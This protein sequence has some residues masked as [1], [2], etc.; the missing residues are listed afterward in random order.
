MQLYAIICNRI[1]LCENVDIRFEANSYYIYARVQ[2]RSCVFRNMMKNF[3]FQMANAKY[4]KKKNFM[5]NWKLQIGNLWKFL[6]MV[7]LFFFFT[8]YALPFIL[9]RAE[10][11]A[12]VNQT[13]NFQGKIINKTGGTNISDGTY[14]FTFKIYDASSGGNQLWSET[15]SSVSVT[16][17][18]FQVALGSTTPLTSVNF[19]QDA[20]WLDITFNGENF[21]SRVRLASVPQAI[22]SQYLGGVVATQSATGFNFA[23]GTS[24]VSTVSFTTA[25]STLTLQPGT[26]GGLTVQSNGANGLTL[27]T[28]GNGAIN[29]GKNNAT[30]IIFGNS[31]TNPSFSFNGTGAFTVTGGGN[32]NITFGSSTGTG[33]V[34]VQPNAGGQAALIVD[35]KGLGDIFT[36]SVSGAGKFVI[37]HSGNVGIQNA[38]LTPQAHLD[39]GV[40]GDGIDAM[41]TAGGNFSID[42]YGHVNGLAFNY[43]SNS[44]WYSDYQNA[45]HSL[46]G[47]FKLNNTGNAAASFDIRSAVGFNSDFSF[48]TLPVASV[49]GATSFAGVVVDQSG[50]GDIFTASSSG[51]PKFTIGNTGSVTIAAGQ[52]YT[53][54]G[55][56][57]VSSGG[58]SG[59]T[60]DSA[61]GTIALANG[62]VLQISRS[63]DPTAA[64]GMIYYDATAGKFKIVENVSGTPTVK[65][66]CNT[67]DAGCGTGG[68][69]TMQGAYNGG[70]TID[71]SQAG[72]GLVIGTNAG[73]QNVTISPNAGGQAALIINDQGVGDIFTASASGTTKFVLSNAGNLGIGSSSPQEELTLGS[74]A[75]LVGEMATPTGATATIQ[76]G[77]SLTNATY[78][79]VVTASDGV[80]ETLKSTETAG[81]T[82]TN[83]GG[84]QHT[85]LVTWNSVL[86]AISYKVYRTTTSGSYTGS[87]FVTSVSTTT[88]TDTGATPTAG[89]PPISTTAYINRF[90]YSGNSWILA[91]HVGIGTS[92]PLAR[93]HV[94]GGNTGGNAAFIVDQT[95]SSANDILTASASGTTK[96]I[97]H[98]DGSIQTA[99]ANGTADL[100]TITGGN[101]LTIMPKANSAGAGGG[102]TLKAGNGTGAAGGGVTI[103]AGTGSVNGTISIGT[104]SQSG[105]TLGRSGATTT[106]NG[107]SITVG[108][109]TGISGALTITS[110]GTTALTVGANGS[111]NPVFTVDA[112]TGSVA[113]GLKVLGAA[114]GGTTAVS[115]TDSGSNANLSL[116]AKGSGTITIGGTSTGNIIIGG[117]A[118]GLTFST[119]TGPSY[120]GTGRPAK[121]ILLSAEYPGAVLT[122]SNSATVNGSMTS[123]A[124]PSATPTSYDWQNYYQWV[125]ASDGTLQD[126]TVAV[127]VTLP[128][129]FSAWATG[130][131]LT[132]AYNTALVSN[133]KN[134]LE[135]YIYKDQD[136]SGI[137]VAFSTGN[138]SGTSKNWTT[139][140]FT[141]T[142]FAGAKTWNTAGATAVIYLRLRSANPV[143]YVQVGDITLNYLAA[144]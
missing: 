36:A 122:A 39:I 78:Y 64:N 103:D 48:G 76:A 50:S 123:D 97:V 34:V 138:A 132:I 82:S 106:I 77:G 59:L 83:A 141:S 79:Y 32:N 57:T 41:R 52:S 86:G 139:I 67:T 87:T 28:G 47:Y 120:T 23:G 74:T 110:N 19:N 100:T 101:G 116:D 75:N 111:T 112:S 124:S 54:S 45:R 35:D 9:S 53:G 42:Q 8:L 140:N 20:L 61:S 104:T 37:N 30:S 81:C 22:N 10:A 26:S 33:T 55:S 130:N 114:T 70:Q 68:A 73:T 7:P 60:L 25:G 94:R 115:V 11:A 85:C 134:A 90:T 96:F 49:S 4:P 18:I 142:S 17:G 29:V 12:G 135:V 95:G 13:I 72:A 144:F 84:G 125:A 44:N 99:G 71:L 69:V 65:T 1:Q 108:G 88:Y 66:L 105:L 3:T 5:G 31:S 14:S 21:T 98:N 127:R 24:T 38:S 131:C 137:P 129:D 93:L 56:V 27:D 63:G 58:S 121:Q 6:V 15:Q 92:S 40:N 118:N 117:T 62:D 91:G 136:T 128:K 43:S 46:D 133:T 119:S 2:A 16:N 89:T 51:A 126:Y 143:N 80:G 102:L 113:T 107:S 109:A